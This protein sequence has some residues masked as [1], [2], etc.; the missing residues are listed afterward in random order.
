[1]PPAARCLMSS[2][3][4]VAIAAH[5]AMR[6]RIT[7]DGLSLTTVMKGVTRVCGSVST[8]NVRSVHPNCADEINGRTARR[9]FGRHSL[10]EAVLVVIQA[11]G[12]APMTNAT[13]SNCCGRQSRAGKSETSL[14]REILAERFARSIRRNSKKTVRALPDYAKR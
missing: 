4:V 7:M 9:E 11:E 14:A 5:E 2:I 8:L 6:L 12:Y 13:E 3:T 1:M 10:R